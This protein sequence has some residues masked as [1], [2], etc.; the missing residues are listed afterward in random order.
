MFPFLRVPTRGYNVEGV[1][2]P[3]KHVQKLSARE[4]RPHG[5]PLPLS[6]RNLK[7]IKIAVR[8]SVWLWAWLEL[9]PREA[10]VSVFS[11]FTDRQRDRKSYIAPDIAPSE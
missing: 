11:D 9:S 2:P 7:I 8:R 4:G 10:S 1:Y 6:S 3:K 5:A